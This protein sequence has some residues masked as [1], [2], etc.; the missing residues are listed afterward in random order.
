MSLSR[1]WLL[2]DL[3]P[4]VTGLV[5]LA[6]RPGTSLLS[7]AGGATVIAWGLV[8]FAA[9]QGYHVP[10]LGLA[11][12]EPHGCWDVPLSFVVAH[13]GRSLLFHRPFPHEDLPDA[14]TVYALPSA[15]AQDVRGAWGLQPVGGSQQLGL[16]P[17][18]SL[19]FAHSCGS[20]VQAR[21]LRAALERLTAS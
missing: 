12:I 20:Y 11:R 17:A 8:R 7:V 18:A 16:V 15:A 2:I 9:Q 3:A 5:L 10:R 13:R 4:L 1:P 21:T 6:S 19:Q 14:Y